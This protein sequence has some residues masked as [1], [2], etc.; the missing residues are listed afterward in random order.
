LTGHAATIAA[1]RSLALT[2]HRTLRLFTVFILYIA[3][4][5]PVGLFYFALPSWQAQ[6]GAS[7]AAVGGVLAMTS[8]PWSLKL[9]NGVF[10]DRFA[11]LPMG[12]RRPW[13]I[14]GQGG[15]VAGLLALAWVNPGPLDAALLGAFAFAIN[16]ATTIQDVAVDGLA[17]DVIPKAEHGRANGF[18]FGGQAIG[19]ALGASLAGTLIATQGLPAAMLAL[20]GLVLAILTLVLVVRERSGERLLPWTAGTAADTN[21]DRHLGNFRVI[22]R[23]LY[24]AMADRPTLLVALALFLGGITQGLILGLLPLHG[25]H[26]L[27]WTKDT[28]A[29]WSAQAN[30]VAGLLGVFV[31]GFFTEWLGARR[32]T[33]VTMLMTAAAALACLW[34]LRSSGS[35]V[36]LI[37]A[38]FVFNA[39]ITLRMVTGSALAMPLC[40]P[41]VAATQ[42]SLMMAAPNLGI[43]AGSAMLGTLDRLGGIPAMLISMAVL[44]VASATVAARSHAGR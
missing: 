5:V 25:V 41:A 35:P 16:M 34:L 40:A 17:V 27:G 43:S 39:L 15:I 21:L 20:A 44:G 14:A 13:I 3:Q 10:M 9:I 38:V 24:V 32:S 36:V 42:F 19:S 8:L 18:M 22:L 29:N 37:A 28:Y 2:E 12:R 31:F 30:L 26:A 33:A 23:T 11:F 7:A 4:G 1:P 6:S